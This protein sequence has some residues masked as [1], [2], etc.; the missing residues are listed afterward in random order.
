[1]II[2]S[3]A[4]KT[5]E[6]FRAH[7]GI[8]TASQFYRILTPTGELS[9]QAEVY[10]YELLAEYA[11]ARHEDG[12]KGAWME[13]GI[14]READAR[15]YYEFLTDSEVEQVGFI[16]KDEQRMIGCSPDGLVLPDGGVEFKCPKASTH[17]KT[18]MYG[19]IDIKYVPQVQGSLYITGLDWWDWV[20]YHPEMPSTRIR[21]LP[22]TVYQRKLDAV[23]NAFIETLLKKRE[24]M[25]WILPEESLV[26]L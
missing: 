25:K 24:E 4:Q 13:Q 11:T 18:L 3:Y 19:T 1:M 20:S 5:E 23:M 15:S 22:D 17:V 12:Y 7:L 2:E 14:E 8:P 16:Y 6:W 26:V 10:M 9:K 21:V